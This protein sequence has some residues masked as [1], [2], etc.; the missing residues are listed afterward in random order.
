MKPNPPNPGSL[1]NWFTAPD[2]P[3]SQPHSGWP[4]LF[5]SQ[6]QI[7]V[8]ASPSLYTAFDEQSL[9][10]AMRRIPVSHAPKHFLICGAV[11]SGKSIGIQILIQSIIARF[12]PTRPAPE[13]LILFDAKCDTVPLLAAMGVNP[14]DEHVWILNPIDERSAVWSI[15]E[16]V[17]SPLMA[18]HLATLLIP[19]ENQSNA[20]YFSDAA[21]ELVYA[22]ILALNAT[23]ETNWDLRDLLCA[24]DCREH[25]AAITAREPRAQVLAERILHD[26]RHSSGV[27][28]TLGTKLGRYEQ[29]AALWHTNRSGRRFSIRKFLDHPGILI[30]GNDPVLRESFWPINA[31]LLQALTHEIL[32]Q[33]NTM[34][35]RHW[36]VLDEFRAMQKVECVHDLLNLGRSKGAVVL[37]GIQSLEGLIEIYRESVA[38]DLLS[39]CAHKTFL[40]A[41][42]PK[43]AH[44]AEEFFG[45]VRRVEMSVTE[46]RGLASGTPT[47]QYAL[48]E[49]SLFIA[50][51]F[52]NL[53]FPEPGGSYMAVCDVP[54]MR[55]VVIL[56]RQFEEVISWL[57]PLPPIANTLLRTNVRDQIL[58]PW[59]A[60][61]VQR[62]CGLPIPVATLAGQID[63]PIAAQDDPE[64]P[65]RRPPRR[66]GPR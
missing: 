35:P 64:L 16:A 51:Y 11:G 20:P 56:R 5:T 47:A 25:I 46:P 19:P 9:V 44:W 52:N 55:R 26:D 42:G 10:W 48:H 12:Q 53:P 50:S 23:A 36:F 62:F 34:R 7:V 29:V 54:S 24:L 30:L 3:A 60:A 8:P 49:R 18:R 40:R 61:E 38:N 37:L 66:W 58:Q 15:G 13:Q 65:Q 59:T 27:L 41:G 43:T 32:R 57:R 6:S 63:L 45:K 21:R 31:I 39:Q 28:S 2:S 33:P 22:V 14:T 4:D 1:W 17:Q